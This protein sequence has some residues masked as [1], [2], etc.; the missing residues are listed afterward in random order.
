M[1]RVHRY[2]SCPFHLADKIICYQADTFFL[3]EDEVLLRAIG[4]WELFASKLLHIMFQLSKQSVSIEMRSISLLSVAVT[5]LLP[6]R[7]KT[8]RNCPCCD[9]ISSESFLL[10][11][12]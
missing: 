4:T 10:K 8:N 7:K 5:C 1:L 3:N 11:K 6:S 12:V 2:L 9:N